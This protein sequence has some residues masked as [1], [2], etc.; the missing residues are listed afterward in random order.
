VDHHV[1][2]RRVAH[3][4]RGAGAQ[5]VRGAGHR[6]EAAHE[7]GRRLFGAQH[8]GGEADRAHARQAH[9]VERDPGHGALH[10][11][12]KRRPPPRVLPV[13]GLQDVADGDVVGLEPRPL[14]RGPHRVRAEV[15]RIDLRERAVEAPDR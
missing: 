5:R 8:R 10:P 7:H 9:V 12:R 14:Q 4:Q 13:G 1:D 2:H 11:A 6:V 3:A 15:D